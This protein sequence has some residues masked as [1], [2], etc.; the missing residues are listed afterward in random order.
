MRFVVGQDNCGEDY[1]SSWNKEELDESYSIP[2]SSDG[3]SAAA[4][5]RATAKPGANYG[6][7]SMA[8]E[9]PASVSIATLLEAGKLVRPTSKKKAVLT[10][11]Q[12]DITSKKW[13]DAMEVECTVDSEKFSSGG[14]R[15]AYHCHLTGKAPTPH[16]ERHWV[17][18]T[19]NNKATETIT[20]TLQSSLEDHCRKQVQMHEVARH[21]TKKF[22]SKAP[23]E[24]GTCFSYNHSYF[25]RVDDKPA[26]VE[27]FVPGSFVK[28][29]NNNGKRA[30]LPGDA[31]EELKDLFYKAE[32]LVHYSYHSSNQKLMLLDIQ[33]SNYNLYDPEIATNEIMD[34]SS[35]EF[36]FCCGN[37]SAV[38]M[39][40]FSGEHECNT[41]CDMMGLNSSNAEA[42]GVP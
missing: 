10:F 34:A 6:T 14:F 36:Y 22:Q 17:V 20:T 7:F 40:G 8:T 15:D 35:H 5:G 32:C 13:Q 2:K 24:F 29:I 19:Y 31:N 16:M 25:T 3:A 11:E 9:F 27:E 4:E 21:L 42:Q 33:G 30:Q 18:K 41:Y 28:I 39:A 23:P 12:F 38:G 37:C 26:T 1:F